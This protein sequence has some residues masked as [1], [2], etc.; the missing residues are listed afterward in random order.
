MAYQLN[1]SSSLSSGHNVTRYCSPRNIVNGRPIPESFDL[2]V[3]EDFL[4]TN[5][6][7]YFHASDRQLQMSGVRRTLA[8]KGFRVNRN[9]G[10]AVLN[11]GVAT[12]AVREATLRFILLGQASDPSHTG[13]FGIPVGDSDIAVA[14]AKSVCE[15]YPATE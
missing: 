5:W 9:G 3:G 13:I 11:V 8:S 1:E 12:Q 15:L 10:F 7:E 4:S 14:L 6:L 2:R